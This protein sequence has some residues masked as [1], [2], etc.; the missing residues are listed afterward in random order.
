ML[1]KLND[2]L[3][4]QIKNHAFEEFPKECCGLIVLKNG[5]LNIVKSRNLFSSERKFFLDPET[6]KREG[7]DNVQAIYH[8]H[9]YEDAKDDW[10]DDR[11]AAA[12]DVP[13]EPARLSGPR[14]SVSRA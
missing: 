10:F 8:S 4:D 11:R 3:K 1:D 12:D 2:N 9:T 14:P 7:F 13:G 6:I 5:E